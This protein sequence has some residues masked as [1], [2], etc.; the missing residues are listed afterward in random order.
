M[1]TLVNTTT[2]TSLYN[3]EDN[4]DIIMYADR[5]VVGTPVDIEILD[6]NFNNTAIVENVS[7]PEDWIGGKYLINGEGQFILNPDY[8]VYTPPPLPEHPPGTP[9]PVIPV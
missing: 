3:F 5:V 4:V 6:C 1:K 8:T 2:G 9:P 7:P